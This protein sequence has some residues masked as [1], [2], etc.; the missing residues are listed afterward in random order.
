MEWGITFLGEL[1]KMKE[2]MDRAWDEL[3][4]EVPGNGDKI[5]QGFEEPSEFDP[6]KKSSSRSHKEAHRP[7]K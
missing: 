4:Q 5:R 6:C 7:N 2:K 1:Q 3:F